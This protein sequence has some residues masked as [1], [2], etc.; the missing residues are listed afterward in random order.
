ML[1]HRGAIRADEAGTS[2]STFSD[3]GWL[4]A[5]VVLGV[6][7]LVLDVR[8]R[9]RTARTLPSAR[10]VRARRRDVLE[11]SP[12]AGGVVHRFGRHQ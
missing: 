2:E 12:G 6:V 5:A 11:A 8:Y 3:V 9:R 10:A 4:L 1:T 7:S